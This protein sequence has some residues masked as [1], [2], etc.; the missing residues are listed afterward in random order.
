MKRVLSIMACLI[1][2]VSA[3]PAV[4]AHGC[5]N[6]HGHG[7]GR[8][9]YYQPSAPCSHSW[10]SG[11]TTSNSYYEFPDAQSTNTSCHWLVENQTSICN[12]CGQTLTR[13]VRQA[14]NHQWCLDENGNYSCTYCTP[15][16]A[17][18]HVHSDSCGW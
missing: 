10:C 16:F 2:M 15:H 13:T 8:Q 18:G 5:G 17:E 12:S 4:A 6:G 11:W 7:C 3:A 1:V 9:R 14:Q